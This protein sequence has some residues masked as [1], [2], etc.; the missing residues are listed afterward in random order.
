[1]A[2]AHPSPSHEALKRSQKYQAIKRMGINVHVHY[3]NLHNWDD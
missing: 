1:M 2:I 3:L